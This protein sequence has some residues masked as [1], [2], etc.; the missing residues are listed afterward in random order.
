MQRI[1]LLTAPKGGGRDPKRRK[2][3]L[4]TTVARRKF[5]ATRMSLLPLS[6]K[7]E[8][9]TSAKPTQAKRTTKRSP[10]QKTFLIPSIS[11]CIRTLA[12]KAMSPRYEKR[13]S[14]K[15]AAQERPNQKRERKQSQDIQSARQSGTCYCWYQA[16][17]KCEGCITKH[18]RWIF[19]FGDGHCL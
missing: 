19:R 18:E 11:A 2:N 1:P 14:R 12:S 10:T 8:F 3:R 6:R 4:C 7:S 9:L 17:S 5:T 16:F 15:K 13:I